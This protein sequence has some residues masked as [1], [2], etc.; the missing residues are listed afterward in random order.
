MAVY[1][2][3]FSVSSN[4]LLFQIALYNCQDC[5]KLKLLCF[6]GTSHAA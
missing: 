1:E 3:R 5:R 6:Y 4:G 2:P